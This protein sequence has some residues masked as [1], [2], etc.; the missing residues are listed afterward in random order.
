MC[1]SCESVPYWVLCGRIADPR[2]KSRGKN[3]GCFLHIPGLPACFSCP[4]D[5][6]EGGGEV[7]SGCIGRRREVHKVGTYTYSIY[8]TQVFGAWL[9]LGLGVEV[10]PDKT[11]PKE[12]YFVIC[13]DKEA[14]RTVNLSEDLGNNTVR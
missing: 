6:L 11:R 4:R 14:K 1:D 8:S 12:A 9:V 3:W 2:E 5:R 10:G 13:V 7:L